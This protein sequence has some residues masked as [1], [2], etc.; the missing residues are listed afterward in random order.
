VID[1]TLGFL[2]GI[3]LIDDRY[4]LD[5]GWSDAPR[6]DY[7]VSL[8]GPSVT[9]MLHTIRAMWTRAQFGRDWRDDVGTWLKDPHKVRRVRKLVQQARLKLTPGEI[10][11]VS[12]GAA[13]RQPMRTAFVVRDNLRQ[14]RTIEQ[15]ALQAISQAR[16][17]VDI[18]TPYF[19]PRRA[20]R[21]ALRHAASRGVR[22]RLLLQGKVDHALAGIV[23]KV[24]YWELQNH[25]V[26]IFEY[27]PAF[28]HAKVLCVDDEWAT[29]GS[30]NL[31][32]LS[33]VMNLEA[34]LIIKDRGFVR[35]LTHA[36]NQDFA[37]SREVPR[38]QK[39]VASA[40]NRGLGRKVV[41]AFAKLY[42]WVAGAGS[43]Y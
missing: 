27:Q 20:V 3:N 8:T 24:L 40:W 31:D 26:R 4:D 5:H 11:K 6:L 23:A 16:E 12:K 2:G 15:A 37:A 38:L 14:R 10:G 28:L 30:S 25:G 19:Y 42:L 13:E 22:V 41:A 7:A 21:L 29:V 34:N 43:R 1:E 39:Q 33:L 36:I 35:T 32:P 9:P 18:V 17:R